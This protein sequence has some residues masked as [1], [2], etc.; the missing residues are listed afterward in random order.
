MN[1]KIGC[2][3][4]LSLLMLFG[5]GCGQ[6]PLSDAGTQ[7]VGNVSTTTNNQD[8]LVIDVATSTETDT[9]SKNNI[10]DNNETT[11]STGVGD[12]QKETITQDK[13]QKQ[14]EKIQVYYTDPEATILQKTE[15]EIHFA[16][17][18]EKYQTTFKALQDDSNPD[19]VSLWSKM[20]LKTV[21]F[22]GGNITLDV[23]MPDDARLGAGGE[24]F[25][26][27]A[28]KNTLFQFEEVVSIDLLVDGASVESLMGHAD[29]EHPM[30]R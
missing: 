22:T 16:N 4:L 12:S 7:A 25:A 15:Q 29:L 18:I 9:S 1:K 17:A 8:D 19:L 23:H 6:K 21:T 2:T 30:V 24:Q 14:S 3:I 5:M 20:E 13:D 27:D 10:S 26:L 28:L 11:E